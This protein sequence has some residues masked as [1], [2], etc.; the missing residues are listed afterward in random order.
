[1]EFWRL[2]AIDIMTKLCCGSDHRLTLEHDAS[3]LQ[4]SYNYNKTITR[5][6]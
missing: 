5:T 4:V 2:L 1:M 3:G 6:T